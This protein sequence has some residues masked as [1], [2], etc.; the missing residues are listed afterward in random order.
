[1]SRLALVLLIFL[2][3]C[4]HEVPPV[5]IPASA[6]A[7]EELESLRTA[8]SSAAAYH[9]DVFAPDQFDKA[10]AFY[11]QAKERMEKKQK[12]E[13]ILEA[14]AFARAHLNKGNQEMAVVH[15]TIPDLM[16]AREAAL[17]AGA[18]GFAEF[19][20]VDEQLR[21]LTR[22]ME[23]GEKIDARERLQL[24]G[25]YS[26]L[27]LSAIKTITLARPQKLLQDAR[28]L[29]AEKLTPQSFEIALQKFR[30]AE[31]VVEN[32]RHDQR[33]IK[34][35][36]NRSSKTTKK[37]LALL[38]K[39]QR[40][41][42]RPQDKALA[43]REKSAELPSLFARQ[44]GE[45]GESAQI[46]RSLDRAGYSFT[47]SEADLSRQGQNLILTM[48]SETPQTYAKVKGLLTELGPGK[49]VVEG[50]HEKTK[51]AAQLLMTDETLEPKVETKETK[52]ENRK[53]NIIVEP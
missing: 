48:K 14:V 23:N 5:Q 49:I 7:T 43:Q 15:S 51:R 6:N 33:R 21:R 1:M 50:P 39:G 46:R 27:E 35:A 18:K 22:E 26:D 16:K 9:L 47:P 37:V 45:P 19:N 24:L 17:A 41:Q 38:Q 32:D 53:L 36:V 2:F 44:Q 30:A 3:G 40:R 52:K 10:M 8:M 28:R 25:K 13:K 12:D 11:N 34:D 20:A 42:L 4:I 31:K 29:N